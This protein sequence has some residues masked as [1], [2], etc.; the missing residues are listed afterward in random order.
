M[1]KNEDLIKA[2]ANAPST[3]AALEASE[4][5]TERYDR[6]ELIE[7]LNEELR[8]ARRVLAVFTGE[9]ATDRAALRLLADTM[10]RHIDQLLKEAEDM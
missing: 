3:I 6:D 7:A 10:V 2:I 5:A 8:T 1:P 4:R 9:Q